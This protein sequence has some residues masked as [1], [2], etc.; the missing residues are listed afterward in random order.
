M[1]LCLSDK[2]LNMAVFQNCENTSEMFTNQVDP[3]VQ[4]TRH[5]FVDHRNII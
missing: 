4:S 3:I 1:K 2:Y 5:M